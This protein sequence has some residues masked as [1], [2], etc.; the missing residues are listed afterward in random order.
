MNG[1]TEKKRRFGF[2]SSLLSITAFI[3]ILIFANLIAVRHKVQFDLTSNRQFTIA[4]QT[5]QILRNLKSPVTAYCCYREFDEGFE[6]AKDLLGMY[7]SASTSFEVRFVDPDKD[8]TLAK[9]FE[10][11]HYSTI[12]LE[13][14]EDFRKVTELTE[15]AL[16]SALI[17][18]TQGETQHRVCFSTGN[19]ELDPESME[20]SG[21]MLL[22]LALQDANYQTDLVNLMANDS[23]LSGCDVLAIIGPIHDPVDEV[24]DRIRKYL[25]D[26]GHLLIALEPGSS[27]KFA[28]LLTE[29]G[30][31]VENSV[32]IDPKGFQNSVQPIVENYPPHEITR[33]F[34]GGMVFHVAGPVSGTEPPRD[35]WMI[36]NLAMT[37]TE[38]YAKTDLR[39]LE[40]GA[41]EFNQSIDIAGPVALAVACETA[42][43]NADPAEADAVKT[44]IVALGDADFISNV[45]LQTFVTHQPFIMNVF[46]WLADEKDLIAIPP[47][48]KISQPLL[49][50][51]VQL[52]AGLVIPVVL[53]PLTV[54]V[55]GVIRILARRRRA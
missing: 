31:Q 32:I 36:H 44:R 47:R 4:P 45:F 49:L 38:A 23:S 2:L 11:N 43:E 6:N 3:A 8:P 25:A 17:K 13:Q 20:S 40:T 39:A 5:D 29:F 28:T 53:L 46:H 54:A 19:G 9:R 42:P 16:T 30:I 14:G 48:E 51:P 22:K 1:T 55:F 52:L 27:G 37:S 26:G 35:G 18:L 50:Q 34:S 24:I 41:L 12:I 33:D 10:L 15:Q 7:D 21:L